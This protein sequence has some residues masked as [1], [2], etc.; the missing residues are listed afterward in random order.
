MELEEI[1]ADMI[2][3]CTV[4]SSDETQTTTIAGVLRSIAALEK[5]LHDVVTSRAGVDR[6]AIVRCIQHGDIHCLLSEMR[7]TL[8]VLDSRREP[9]TA[10]RQIVL[11]NLRGVIQRLHQVVEEAFCIASSRDL[12]WFPAWQRSRVRQDDILATVHIAR[13]RFVRLLAIFP[14]PG[15]PPTPGAQDEGSGPAAPAC[16]TLHEIALEDE[17]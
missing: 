1:S 14:E 10:I 9:V 5:T 11:R 7:D 4:Q 3:V 15:A 8:Q 2:Q 6:D 12:R 13:T 16:G 17:L